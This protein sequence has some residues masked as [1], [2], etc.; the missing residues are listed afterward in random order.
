[1]PTDSIQSLISVIASDD[2]LFLIC[3]CPDSV[4]IPTFRSTERHTSHIQVYLTR[5]A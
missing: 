2:C 3:E 5:V 1:M 4:A